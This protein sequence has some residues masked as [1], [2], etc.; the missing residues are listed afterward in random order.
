MTA[1]EREFSADQDPAD[2]TVGEVVTFL[3]GADAE[4]FSRVQAAEQEGKA[5]VG[6]T[7]LEKPRVPLGGGD[8]YTRVEVDAYPVR[9]E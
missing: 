1:A 3:A 4:S 2:F 8:G 7:G 6:I 9:Q 5:R